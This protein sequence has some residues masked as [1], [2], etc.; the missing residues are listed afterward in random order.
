MASK[1]LAM[2]RNSCVNGQKIEVLFPLTNSLRRTRLSSAQS[3]ER[4]HAPL[5]GV[6]DPVIDTAAIFD[7]SIK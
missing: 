2:L 4:N 5:H 7:N 3:T 1:D 6:Y